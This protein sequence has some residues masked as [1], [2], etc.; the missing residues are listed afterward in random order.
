M[1][2]CERREEI[3]GREREKVE[4]E[5]REREREEREISQRSHHQK[6]KQTHTHTQQQKH[7]PPRSPMNT[8][9]ETTHPFH[10]T[11]HHSTVFASLDCHDRSVDSL[12]AE[13]VLLHACPC[14]CKKKKC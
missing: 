2:W 5:K 14:T 6:Q 10:H 11:P 8:E 1:V 12:E 9:S 3:E 4:R 7:S 13:L